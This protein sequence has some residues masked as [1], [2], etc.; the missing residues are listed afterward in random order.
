MGTITEEKVATGLTR[1][2]SKVSLQKNGGI[3]VVFEETSTVII[4]NKPVEKFADVP[5][6]GR[7]LP[8]PDLTHAFSLLRPHLAILCS[9]LDGRDPILEEIESDEKFMNQFKVTGFSIGGSGESEG[10]VLIGTKKIKRGVLNL[11][12]P[13][14]KYFDEHDPYDYADELSHLTIHGANE[15]NLYVDGKIAPDAQGKLPLDGDDKSDLEG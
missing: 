10:V 8:H 9:Q 7:S 2:I 6:A 13:F 4:N 5:Y 12:T 3:L 14:T 1:K 15:G 11:A